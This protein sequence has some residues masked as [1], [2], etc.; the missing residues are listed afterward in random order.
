[1]ELFKKLNGGRP[2]IQVTHSEAARGGKRSSSC[3]TDGSC[4]I[5]ASE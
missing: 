1:M 4:N 5:R 2:I 3:A